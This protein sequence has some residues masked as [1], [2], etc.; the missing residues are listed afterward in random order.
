[1][2]SILNQIND[3]FGA[4]VGYLVPILFA[5][6]YGIPLIVLTLMTGAVVFTFYFGFAILCIVELIKEEED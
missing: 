3:V 2:Q 4:L 5:D 1:M 6:I